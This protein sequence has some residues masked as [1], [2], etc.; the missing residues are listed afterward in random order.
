MDQPQ[1][2]TPKGQSPAIEH[3]QKHLKRLK[4]DLIAST[5]ALDLIQTDIGRVWTL[6]GV[7]K[8]CFFLVSLRLGNS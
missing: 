5:T 8:V 6:L 2:E 4:G 7:M 3:V 1:E